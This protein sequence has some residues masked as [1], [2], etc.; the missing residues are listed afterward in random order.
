MSIPLKEEVPV[1]KSQWNFMT[2]HGNVFVFIAKQPRITTRE[3]AL[4]VGITERS[5]QKIILDLEADGYIVKHKEGVR[6][7]YTINPEVP[8]RHRIQRDHAVGDLLKALG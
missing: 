1:E 5:V 4:A 8:M 7:R 6:N 2:S 3:I